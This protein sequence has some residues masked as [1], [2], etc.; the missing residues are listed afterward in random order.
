MSTKTTNYKLVKP[1]LTDTADITA[2]NGNWDTID[3]ELKTRATLGSDGKIPSSQLPAMNYVPTTEK[4]TANGVATLDENGQVPASQL[5][6]AASSPTGAASTIMD[7]NLT[8]NRALIS[9]GSGKVAVSPVTSTE[10]GY[11]DGVTSNVQ[12]QLGTK[13]NK[14]GDE[15]T[16]ALDF[17]NTDEFRAISKTRLIGTTTYYVNWGCGQLGGEGIVAMELYLPSTTGGTNAVLGRLEIG[18]R[19]VS[20]LDANNKRTYLYASGLTAASVES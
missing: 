5:G 18:S 2:M 11:L 12:T 4:A 8:A 7:S 10:L 3:N 1:A 9:N 19:G 13:V 17:K 15:L 14:S 6:N 16:G 20:F